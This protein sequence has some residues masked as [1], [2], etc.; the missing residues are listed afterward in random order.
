[1]VIWL[2]VIFVL[3]NDSWENFQQQA[4]IT[5]QEMLF[6]L[7]PGIYKGPALETRTILGG[8]KYKLWN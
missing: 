2:L 3:I 4:P 8:K 6:P 7:P 1:M 5:C